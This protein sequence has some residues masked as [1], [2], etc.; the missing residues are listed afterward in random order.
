MVPDKQTRREVLQLGVGTV[1]AASLSGC[2]SA[3]PPLGS[4]LDFGRV[5][6]PDA[7]DPTYRQWLPTPSVAATDREHYNVLFR[8]PSAIDYV[9]PVRFAVPKKS[10]LTDLDYVGVDYADY[11][12]LLATPFG[13]VLEGGFDAATVTDTLADTGYAPDGSYREFDLFARSDDPRTVAVGDDTVVYASDRLHRAADIR[14]L[15]DAK[16]GRVERYHE[17][18]DRFARASEAIGESRMVEFLRPDDART[19]LK[20]EGFRFDGETAYHVVKHLYPDDEPV[21]T[22]RL[23]QRSVQKTLLTREVDAFHYAERGQTATVSGRIPP[24]EGL[25]PETEPYPPHATWGGTVDPDTGAVTLRHE[26]GTAVDAARLRYELRGPDGSTVQGG[27][28]WSGTETVEPGDTTTVSWDGPASG[29]VATFVLQF[30]AE[31]ASYGS[32]FTVEVGGD[33]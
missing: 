8:R 24:G 20:A 4:Q 11:D 13:I 5:D 23:K 6:V 31:G 32:L 3:L 27:A 2:S 25:D 9:A 14:A 17:A 29:D 15:V 10:L 19:W 30:T 28:P 7:D 26:A 16:A 1:A 22:D 12:R 21:P 18:D 33:G